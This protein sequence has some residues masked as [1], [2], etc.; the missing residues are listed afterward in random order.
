[1]VLL[2]TF[3]PPQPLGSFGLA[4]LAISY[5]LPRLRRLA[6]MFHFTT[7]VTV[8]LS[9]PSRSRT[10]PIEPSRSLPIH[11]N[12][13]RSIPI[14]PDPPVPTIRDPSRSIA[15]PREPLRP[16]IQPR[17]AAVHRCVLGT[18]CI[19]SRH[20]SGANPPGYGGFLRVLAALLRS[21]PARMIALLEA[22]EACVLCMSLAKARPEELGIFLRQLA[23]PNAVFT[24][25]HTAWRFL[26]LSPRLRELLHNTDRLALLISAICHDLDHP[27]TSCAPV[28]C[29][30]SA[31]PTRLAAALGNRARFTAIADVP[32]WQPLAAGTGVQSSVR[33]SEVK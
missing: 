30:P 32:L 23:G 14:P 13:S 17:A 28:S 6:G 20:S 29:T 9:Q 18:S 2:R 21:L 7:S 3:A 10:L 31:G 26:A 1:M 33:Q 24:V 27:G 15:T 22:A 11:P 12:P 16:R 4:A 25:T 5:H 8:S 19:A